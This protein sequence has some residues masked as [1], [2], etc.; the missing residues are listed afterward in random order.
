MRG[1]IVALGKL[2][3]PILSR[4][5][6][7]DV[8][9]I[10]VFKTGA[11]G[12]VLLSTAFVRALREKY[13]NAVIDY[14]TGDWAS[15]SLKGNTRL[16]NVFT[17]DPKFTY[18]GYLSGIS[19]LLGL[20]KQIRSHEYDV[21]FSLD[22]DW[23]AMCFGRFLCKPKYHVGFDRH[24]EGFA[25]NYSVPYLTTIRK[26][27]IEYY[28]DLLKAVGG[29]SSN[30]QTELFL[31]WEHE[32][33]AEEFLKKH[34][35]KDPIGINPTGGNP[36]QPITGRQWPLNRFVE[37]G[38][39]L[40]EEGHQILLFGGPSDQPKLKEL[41]KGTNAVVVDSP[42]LLHAAAVLK[43]CKLFVCIDSSLMHVAYAVHTPTVSIFGRTDPIRK[44][45]PGKNHK[46]VWH[47]MACQEA[48]VFAI[49]NDELDANIT[50]VQ[51]SEVLDSM[52]RLLR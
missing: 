20:A 51:V 31:K 30:T 16:N 33:Y 8:N 22:K 4:K 42:T 21:M 25:N 45:P 11:M 23:K 46:Y 17:F 34:G 3:R 1:L 37:L 40:G 48:E 9:R 6:N 15:I 41:F 7:V 12:D 35:I 10:C 50:K 27:E 38:K 18:G 14:W 24:G 52:H 36:G 43:K 2:V 29:S 49:Y 28:L 19:K 26:N 44:A 32:K 47:P 5:K 13:P 39:K